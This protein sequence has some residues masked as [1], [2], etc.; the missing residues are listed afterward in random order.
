[1]ITME[2]L[3]GIGFGEYNAAAIKH[4]CDNEAFCFSENEYKD[5]DLVFNS[6]LNGYDIPTVILKNAQI[7]IELLC[8]TYYDLEIDCIKK[9]QNAY[10]L[11]GNA[12]YFKEDSEASERIT[13]EFED[14]DISIKST[15]I[16]PFMYDNCNAWEIIENF[17]INI[18]DRIDCPFIKPSEK[19]LKLKPLISDFCSFCCNDEEIH[20]DTLKSRLPQDEKLDTL[21]EKLSKAKNNYTA[22][23][24]LYNYLS[25]RKFESS[26]RTILAE[27]ESSQ[28]DYC[29]DEISPQITSQLNN[30]HKQID[31][32]MLANGYLGTYPSCQKQAFQKFIPAITNFKNT[33][34]ILSENTNIIVECSDNCYDDN[35]DITFQVSTLFGK[36]NP[37]YDKY[38]CLFANDGK[39]FTKIHF[40]SY[41]IDENKKIDPFSSIELTTQAICKSSE[42]KHL[43]KQE[44]EAIENTRGI[45]VFASIF[46]IWLIVSLLFGLFMTVGMMLIELIICL[47]FGE[48][49]GFGELFLETPWWAIFLAGWLGFAT[50][51]S[52][53]TYY[54]K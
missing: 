38:S 44:N 29:D 52:I 33:Y 14:I 39:D 54:S 22:K 45:G 6:Y 2:D 11:I 20:F 43:N 13:I 53:A 17:A 9:S 36:P 35:G 37:S 21:F 18:Q 27:F 30:I 31:E 34:T 16:K 32:I 46:K 47:I 4:L 10:L 24:N 42:F 51:M 3:I 41:L 1:M 48:M 7:S 49:A 8:D 5:N 12:K 26:W 40:L 50:L 23:R 19:E 25:Q 28:E 15:K